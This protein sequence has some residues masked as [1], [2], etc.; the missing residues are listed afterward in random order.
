M[1]MESIH[2]AK[3]VRWFD[4]VRGHSYIL[5]L[6]YIQDLL[7]TFAPGTFAHSVF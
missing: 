4:T 7:L 2:V 1:R 6:R 5:H 3:R